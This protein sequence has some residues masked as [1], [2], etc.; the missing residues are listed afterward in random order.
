MRFSYSKHAILGLVEDS[1]GLYT[2]DE[3]HK[4]LEKEIPNISLMTVYRN[5]KKLTKEGKLIPIHIN[6]TV[7]YCGNNNVHYH[8]HCI[9][10][11]LVEDVYHEKL[12]S[13]IS[14]SILKLL[15]LPCLG[16]SYLKPIPSLNTLKCNTIFKS[17]VFDMVVIISSL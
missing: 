14:S 3:I 12:N 5:I 2:V 6:K 8:K 11:G 17:L 1:I 4:K 10:C 16:I 9:V 7:H 15:I 13:V